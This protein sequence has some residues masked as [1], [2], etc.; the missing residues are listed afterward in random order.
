MGREEGVYLFDGVTL[1]ASG[2][3]ELGSYLEF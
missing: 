1:C 3:E 2:L